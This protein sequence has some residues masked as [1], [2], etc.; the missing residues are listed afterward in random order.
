MPLHVIV[1][2]QWGDE[3]KGRV[4]ALLAAGADVVARYPGGDNAGHTVT[5][6]GPAGPQIY[7][8]HLLPSGIIQPH[9]VGV[10]GHGM[11]IN[12]ARLLAEMAD[13]RRLGGAGD[14]ERAETSLGAHLITPAHRA[15]DEADE[16]DRAGGEGKIGTTG[17]GIG[18]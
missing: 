6:N 16:A 13:L 12:P 2:A 15:L 14:P 8:L 1:G 3:G 18:P 9:V 4:T 17:R 10:P 11:V 7:K 5:V